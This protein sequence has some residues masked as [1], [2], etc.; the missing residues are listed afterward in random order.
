MLRQIIKIDKEK[1]DGCGLCADACHEGAIA[2]INGKAKLVRDDHCDGLGDCLPACPRDAISFIMKDTL[3]FNPVPDDV[4]LMKKKECECIDVVK[5]RPGSKGEMTRWPIQ[6]K[7][8]SQ[9]AAFFNGADLLIASDCTAFVLR[10]FHERFVKD[11]VILIG[12]P[13]LDREEYGQR[14]AAIISQNDIRSVTLV[15]MDIPCCNEMARMV[16]EALVL[17]KKDIPLN[18]AVLSTDGT[19]VG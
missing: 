1:C 8:V 18:M 11:R 17:C 5:N 6:L 7:L 14:I 9:K 16:R 15:R 2:V 10:D 4:P 19:V 13:K 3:P 12:C